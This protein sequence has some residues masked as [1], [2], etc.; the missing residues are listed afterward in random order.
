M[1]SG[2]HPNSRKALEE[3]RKKG[4][5]S[6]VCG[7]IAVKAA[8]KSHAVRREKGFIQRNLREKVDPDQVTD[9]IIEKA[10]VDGNQYFMKILL[11]MLGEDKPIQNAEANGKDDQLLEVLKESLRGT[12]DE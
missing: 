11:E 6:S 1:P 12:N 2:Q 9:V 8:E 10:L 7:E 5:F 3:N 4:Q